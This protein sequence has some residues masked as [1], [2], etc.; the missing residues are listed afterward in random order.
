MSKR[1]KEWA[2]RARADLTIILGG[3]CVA[4]GKKDTLELDCIVPQGDVHHKMSTDQRMTFY[5]KQHR[6]RANVQLLCSKCHAKK[7]ALDSRYNL[8]PANPVAVW[9]PHTAATHPPSPTGG[10]LLDITANG[11]QATLET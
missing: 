11:R 7:S 9:Q 8:P 5:R 10:T 4:C 3:K 1:V 6:E 2:R